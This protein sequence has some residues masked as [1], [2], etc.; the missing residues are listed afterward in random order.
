MN[1]T[2]LKI[3]TNHEGELLVKK[4]KA[5]G[6]SIVFT[7]GCFDLLHLGHVD[8]LEKSRNLGDRLIVG[9]N[10]DHSARLLKGSDR[11]INDANAR[12]RLLASLDFVDMVILFEEETPERL[13]K[14]FL[15]DVLVK[16]SDYKIGNIAGANIVLENGGSVETIELLESYSTT[17]LIRKIKSLNQE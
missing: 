12:M 3:V 7:N 5:Q 13:I 8:Y 2:K 1:P 14:A 15:P 11:P 17:Q 10:S 6:E 16:G 4:W 9:V